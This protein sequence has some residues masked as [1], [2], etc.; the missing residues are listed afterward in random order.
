MTASSNTIGPS[1]NSTLVRLFAHVFTL[2]SWRKVRAGAQLALTRT[3]FGVM[4]RFAPRHALAEAQSLFITPPRFQHSHAE[5]K[6]IASATAIPINTPFGQLAAWRVG[7]PSAPAIVLCHGWGGR[8]AQLRGF[9]PPLVAS[10]YQVVFFDH[11]GHGF[12]DGRQAALVDFW[13]GLEAVWDA[14]LD[15]GVNVHGMVAHSLGGAA[16]A[17]ALRRSLTRKHINAPVPRVVLIAPPA[18]LI[19]YSKM[20]ARY[21]GI[22]ERI[23]HAMQWRFEQRYG[24]SWQEFELPHSVAGIRAPAL[25]IHDKTDRETKFE[26]GLALASTW[27]DARFVATDKLGHRRILRDAKVINHTIDFLKDRVEFQRPTAIGTGPSPLY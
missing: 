27:P 20:F 4:S 15:R 13:R 11:V 10:G 17:S 16:V 21:V 24:V 7:D 1:R 23:R 8:G 3:R 26:G 18:S 14:L 9:V 25:F 2:P 6:L 19:R 5:Q 12:S 22:T